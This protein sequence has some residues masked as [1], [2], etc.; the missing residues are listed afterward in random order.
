MTA[1]V[2]E[3]VSSTRI[4]DRAWQIPWVECVEIR[5]WATR[6][7]GAHRT[8][9]KEKRVAQRENSKELQRVPFEY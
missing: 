3:R 9:N 6:A 5:I 2:F 1:P 8:G 7:A 4:G